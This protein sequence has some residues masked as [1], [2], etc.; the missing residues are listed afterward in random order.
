MPLLRIN[1]TARGLRMHGSPQS[2]KALLAQAALTQ[3]PV[4]IMV[5]GY[6]YS[7]FVAG[8]CPHEKIFARA[9]WPAALGDTQGDTLFVAFGWHA[10]G[11]F[12]GTHATA[13]TQ[14]EQ[15]AQ[16]VTALRPRGPV[17]IIAHSLGATLALAAL[18]HLQKGDVG[19]VVLLSGAAHLE[20]AHA[21]LA[22][23]A[24]RY[25]DLFHV[26]S[27]SNAVFDFIFE[28]LMGGTGAIGRGLLHA[29][30]FTVQID[31]PETLAHLAELGFPI[32]P[33]QRRICHWSSYTREGV[34]AL[35]T[36]LLR[37]ALGRDA[38]RFTRPPVN[39]LVLPTQS[40]IMAHIGF[41]NGHPHEHL[42]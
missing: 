37:G 14:A 13:C 6:K 18:P 39:P 5:H 4:V 26:T 42:H 3:G 30:A 10:R 9:G 31:C 40:S 22:T 21:A 20:L 7:P 25:S 41:D 16:I 15:L 23:P 8:H 36:A 32:A 2:V 38:L 29:N 17:H 11:A 27:A 33:P 12:A 35:N 1:A 19:R 28:R 24:G 34:M